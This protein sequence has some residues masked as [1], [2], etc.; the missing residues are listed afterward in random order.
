M[1]TSQTLWLYFSLHSDQI[2]GRLSLS[3][4]KADL[5]ETSSAHVQLNW[6]YRAAY[7]L[8]SIIL[9]SLPKIHWLYLIQSSYLC[10]LGVYHSRAE[11]KWAQLSVVLSSSD[12][13]MMGLNEFVVSLTVE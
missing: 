2:A 1:W 5:K 13:K 6:R 10:G 11:E 8:Q 3:T 7:K 12:L 4:V 9:F